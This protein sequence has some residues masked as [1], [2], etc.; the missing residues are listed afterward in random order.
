[1][2][3]LLAYH[4]RDTVSGMGW[5]KGKRRS[6]ENKLKISRTKL[7]RK[8]TPEAHDAAVLEAIR[9]GASTSDEMMQQTR[10]TDKE[11]SWAIC[12]LNDRNEIWYRNEKPGMWT[13]GWQIKKKDWP[14]PEWA[15]RMPSVQASPNPNQRRRQ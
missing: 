11:V 13:G 5:P 1:M 15:T 4:F 3:A 12:R 6:E 7:A 10:L 2:R 9:N 8:P 14:Y